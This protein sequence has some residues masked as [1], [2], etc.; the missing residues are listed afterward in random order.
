VAT[1]ISNLVGNP[2]IIDQDI[3]TSV[4]IDQKPT[5]TL[6]AIFIINVKL[7][8]FWMQSLFLQFCY[9]LLSTRLVSGWQKNNANCQSQAHC[10]YSKEH[11]LHHFLTE[12]D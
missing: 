11:I 12:Q 9:G 4:G 10:K 1:E 5:K 8:K 7:M 3:K 2:S 6:D